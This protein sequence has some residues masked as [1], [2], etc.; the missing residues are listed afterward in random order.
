MVARHAAGSTHRSDSWSSVA[1]FQ[2]AD[3]GRAR[4]HQPVVRT[5]QERARAVYQPGLRHLPAGRHGAGEV[6]R[7]QPTSSPSRCRSTSGTISAGR[8]RSPRREHRAAE[9]LRQGARRRRHLHAAGRRQRHDRRQWQRPGRHRGG[10]QGHRGSA[11]GRP[12]ADPLPARAQLDQDRG[13]RCA[14]GLHYKEATIWFA[15]VQKS[16]QVPV[17]RGD[18]EGKTLTYTNIVR[19]MLPVGSWNGKAMSLQLA[20]TAVMRPGD[21]GRHHS[22]AGGQGRPHHRRRLD[23]AVVGAC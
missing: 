5:A 3:A 16:A 11:E 4:R 9:G 21:R 20:R 13:G 14:A 19:E 2:R 10:D 22:A 8:T 6:R 15:V 23:R 1:G 7:A 17:Q 12:R 18:N